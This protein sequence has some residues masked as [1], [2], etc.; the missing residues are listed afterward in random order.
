MK[1]SNSMKKFFAYVCAIAMVVSSMAFYGQTSV[2]ASGSA[3]VEGKIYT[4]T[5]GDASALRRIL[6]GVA[7]NVH[8]DLAQL[9]LIAEHILMLH[10]KRA[11]KL[12]SLLRHGRF[13]GRL[14]GI[15]QAFQIANLCL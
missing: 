15:G 10:M 13:K 11:G 4:V 12:Q 1:L 5:D 14:D 7:H 2:E 9:D 3:A 6:D 8:E